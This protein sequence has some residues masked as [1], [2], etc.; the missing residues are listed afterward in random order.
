MENGSC[1]RVLADASWLTCVT[2]A[3]DME[4]WKSVAVAALAWWVMS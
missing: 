3:S 1:S 2:T 4:Y